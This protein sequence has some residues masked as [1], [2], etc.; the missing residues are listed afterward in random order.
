MLTDQ[1]SFENQFKH[2][3]T[4]SQQQSQQKTT[5][6]VKRAKTTP[7]MTSNDQAQDRPGPKT[8]KITNHFKWSCIEERYNTGLEFGSVVR[9]E[10]FHQ[11]RGPVAQSL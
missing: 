6:K 1:N 8:S 9:K 3:V 11:R 2:F 5:H 10:K 4:F 7:K